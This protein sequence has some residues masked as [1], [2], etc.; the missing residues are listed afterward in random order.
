MK[1]VEPLRGRAAFDRVFDG[2]RKIGGALTVCVYLVDRAEK[3]ALRVGFAVSSRQFN[4]VRRNRVRRL[5]R[6]AVRHECTPLYAALTQLRVSADLVMVFRPRPNL[7]VHRLTLAPF[8]SDVADVL[9]RLAERLLE[10]A[11]A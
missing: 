4:A 1:P 11:H 10:P 6:E 5:M 8:R 3:A 9:G 2:G 7:D